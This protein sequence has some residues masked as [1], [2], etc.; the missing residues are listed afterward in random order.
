MWALVPLFYSAMHLMHARFDEDRIPE[1]ER[2]PRQHRSLRGRDGKIREW[3]TFDVVVARYS[4]VSSIYRSLET[5]SRM[6]RYKS[7][8]SFPS[9][10][11]WADYDALAGAANARPSREVT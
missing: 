6:V 1:D 11:F 4:G 2:H 10:R 7:P 8:S 9:T 5:V 3:G